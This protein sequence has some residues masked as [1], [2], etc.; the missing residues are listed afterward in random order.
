MRHA[1]SAVRIGQGCLSGHQVSRADPGCS[2]RILLLGRPQASTADGPQSRSDCCRLEP[3]VRT[4]CCR[5]PF[6]LAAE[7]ARRRLP[8]VPYRAPMRESSPGRSYGTASRGRPRRPEVCLYEVCPAGFQD[9]LVSV[10]PVSACTCSTLGDKPQG[11]G[12]GGICHHLGNGRFA[13]AAV[14]GAVGEVNLRAQLGLIVADV[15][16]GDT[17]L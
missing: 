6:R 10:L 4:G 15:L 8:G 11:R 5:G 16:D 2:V 14:L 12:G 1:I 9:A 13:V 7:G 17:G 3:S